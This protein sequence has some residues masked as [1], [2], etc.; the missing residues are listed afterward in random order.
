MKKKVMDLNSIK[1]VNRSVLLNILRENGPLSRKDIALLSGLSA[2]AITIISNEMIGEGIIKEAGHAERNG[3]AGRKKV[4][5]DIEKEHRY[6]IGINI[7]KDVTTVAISDLNLNILSTRQFTTN[8]DIPPDDFLNEALE[9][10]KNMLWKLDISKGNVLGIGVGIVG[11]VDPS[12]GISLD[13]YGIW[14]CE[15]NIGNILERALKLPVVV[16][17][18]VRTLALAEISCS[19]AKNINDFV[20]I[21]HGP[22]IGA[23]IIINRRLIYGSEN[24]AGEI[25][26]IIVDYNGPK[27][28]C[29]QRGC[30]ETV[31]STRRMNRIMKENFSKEKTPIL[32]ELC[33]GERDDITTGKVF[34]AYEKDDQFVKGV[35]SENILYMATAIIELLKI[36]DPQ[37]IIF[38]GELFKYERLMKDLID[39]ISLLICDRDVKKKIV[40][41]CLEYKNKGIGAL[42]LALEKL[43]YDTGAIYK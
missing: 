39:K 14:N 34:M 8:S 27:C 28:N 25:G 24:Q 6:I 32:F 15:V 5:I 2:G 4:L 9:C 17:N 19:A 7:E 37:K 3:K 16:D 31:V 20:F 38:F 1:K 11:K 42:A 10:I 12:K 41:S 35:I 21:K 40:T 22:G 26:H 13:A 36:L 18:N 33:N 23:A 30:L 29:G 43:F